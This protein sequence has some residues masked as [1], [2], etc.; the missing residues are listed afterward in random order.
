MRTFF[1]PDQGKTGVLTIAHRGA[2]SI[3]PE[4]TLRAIQKAH[5]VGAD[6]CEVDVRLTADDVPVLI[7]DKALERVSNIRELP[8]FRHRRS[9]AVGSMTLHELHCLDCGSWFLHQDPF[10]CIR[11]GKLSPEDQ[12][13][14]NGL[15]LATL[16][17][18]LELIKYHGWMLNIEVKDVGSKRNQVL[19]D[20]VCS[21]VKEMG[22]VRQVLISSLRFETL[23]AVRSKGPEFN[24]AFVDSVVHPQVLRRLQSIQAT[25][26]HPKHTLVRPDLI[27]SCRN[28]G[29]AVNVWTVNRMTDVR[30]LQAMGVD[31]IITDVPQ[32][33]HSLRVVPAA[34]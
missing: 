13:S 18:A 31:G 1:L 32:R 11:A 23:E 9:W 26:Y 24:L 30:L 12:A 3:A 16:E 15:P 2:R 22:L 25:A 10:R 14:Y 19:V 20:R 33:M 34:V 8:G 21:M 27:R 28:Q 7:H 6:M 4:N 29:I 17:Q 5:N